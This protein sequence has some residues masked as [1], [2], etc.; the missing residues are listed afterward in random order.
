MHFKLFLN[1]LW[2]RSRQLFLSEKQWYHSDIFLWRKILQW[3][4]VWDSVY[5]QLFTA[6]LLETRFQL[7]WVGAT[8]L[9]RLHV[10]ME[11]GLLSSGGQCSKLIVIVNRSFWE[12]ALATPLTDPTTTTVVEYLPSYK[13]IKYRI[14]TFVTNFYR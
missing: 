2:I 6:N 10:I 14:C 5:L 3:Q 13:M 9:S 7:C 8:V 4:I 1:I 12:A 11:S